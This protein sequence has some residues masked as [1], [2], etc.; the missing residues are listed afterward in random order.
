M[1]I[2]Y[3]AAVGAYHLGVRIAARWNPKAKAWVQGREGLWERLNA[4]REALKGCLW[5]H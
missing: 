4:K 2:L 1:P 3:S 5:M